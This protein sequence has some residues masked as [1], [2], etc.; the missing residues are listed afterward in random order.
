MSPNDGRESGEKTQL[1]LLDVFDQGQFPLFLA[2]L[3]FSRPSP[4]LF[5]QPGRRKTPAT[6]AL[7]KWSKMV[8]LGRW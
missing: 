2:Y 4:L 6:G 5:T 7:E 1:S 3:A 8:V